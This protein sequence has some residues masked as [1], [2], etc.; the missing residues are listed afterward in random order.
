MNSARRA[1]AWCGA[2]ALS[3]ACASVLAQ[4]Q[5]T[6]AKRATQPHIEPARGG[7]CVAEPELM[8]RNHVSLLKHQRD[9]TVHRGIRDERSS[10]KGCV[11]CHASRSSNSVAAAKTDFCVACHT[12]ASVK[13]DCFECHSSKPRPVALTGSKSPE[14]SASTTPRPPS[15]PQGGTR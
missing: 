15:P 10:L 5:L 9:E 2:V 7:V 1:L 6:V 14:R 11:D 12:F 13:V 8:R 4:A 3:L